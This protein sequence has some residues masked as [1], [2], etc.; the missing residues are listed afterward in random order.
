MSVLNSFSKERAVSLNSK[1]PTNMISG[2]ESH[3]LRRSG[4]LRD[5]VFAYH[6]ITPG[7]S[8]Y[9]YAVTR[10]DFVEHLELVSRLR[11]RPGPKPSLQ[12][13]FDDGHIS[14]Y[15]IALPLLENHSCKATFFVIVGRIGQSQEF[16]TWEHLRELVT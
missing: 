14:N 6:E 15:R 9:S 4:V 1:K 12:V 10:Q 3:S 7:T 16:M 11:D 2:L 8:A 13:S 5:T